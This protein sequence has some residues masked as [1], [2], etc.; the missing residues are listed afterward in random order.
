MLRISWQ[1]LGK[2]YLI[3]SNIHNWAFLLLYCNEARCRQN[4]INLVHQCNLKSLSVCLLPA[5]SG[6][7]RPKQGM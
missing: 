5:D 4:I 1:F 2:D 3:F 6:C 7:L